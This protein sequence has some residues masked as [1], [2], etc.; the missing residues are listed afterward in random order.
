MSLAADKTKWL[1]VTHTFYKVIGW[2][3]VVFGVCCGVMAWRAGGRGLSLFFLLFVALGIYIV[4]NSGSTQMDSQYIRYYLPSGRHQIRWD[5]VRYI[6]ID[7]QGGN[8]VF[9]GENKRLAMNG[10]VSWSGKDK[11][12]MLKLIRIQIEKYGI[13]VRQT[14]KA[15]LRLSRNTKVGG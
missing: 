3:C 10:P 14:E 11:L 8:M 12:E 5:E 2:V 9:V 7:K 6:E 13:Q 1:V 15:M 4:L